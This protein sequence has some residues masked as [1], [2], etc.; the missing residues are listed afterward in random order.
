MDVLLLIASGL[1]VMVPAL[2]PNPGAVI[3]GGGKPVDLGREWKGARIL[4]DGKTWNGL[5]GGIC[6]GVLI[7]SLQILGEI[8]YGHYLPGFIGLGPMPTAL[9]AVATLAI[10]SLLGDMGGAFI[11]RRRGMSRG[12]KAPVLD[13]YDS[14]VGALL[15]T[16]LVFP[17]W[18]LRTLVLEDAW[19]SLLAVIVAAPLLHRSVNII[20]YKAGLKREPW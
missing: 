15:L 6:F 12:Q 5:I 8:N 3:F 16:L 4:G 17:D 20:G 19:V 18:T 1:W 9:G 11:K 14:I 10:G 7:G 13:Q 2:V